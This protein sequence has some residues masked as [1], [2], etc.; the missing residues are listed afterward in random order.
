M[1]AAAVTAGDDGAIVDLATGTTLRTLTASARSLRWRSPATVPA[2]TAGD[3]G[4]IV[5]DLATGTTL[6]AL[7]GEHAVAAVAVT[8][9]GSRAVTAAM[10][11]A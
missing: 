2:V 7:T 3:D 4:A 8:G 11:A 10:T 6:R 5:W 9:D 1:T